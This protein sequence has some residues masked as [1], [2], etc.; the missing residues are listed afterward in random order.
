MNGLGDIGY[1]LILDDSGFR[2]T[3]RATQ[4]QLQAL[5]RQ[6]ASTGRAVDAIQSSISGVGGSFHNFVATMGAV[7]FAMLDVH[8]LFLALPQSIMDTSGQIE[9]LTKVLEGMSS[10]GTEA[11]RQLEAVSGVNFILGLEQRVPFSMQ[12][13]TDMFVKL[14][15]VGIDPAKGAAEALTNEV[16]KFGGGSLQLKEAS[17][18]IQQMLGKGSVSLQELRMQ[19]SQAIPN[20]AQKMA[21]AM[22]LS[23]NDLITKIKKGQ[24]E[25]SSAVGKMLAAFNLDSLGAGEAQMQTWIGLE[26]KLNTQWELWKKSVGDA[27]FFQAAKDSLNEL[28]D[29]FHT[30]EAKEWAQGLSDGLVSAIGYGKSLTA[31]IIE[32]KDQLKLAGE[33]ALAL[34][35]VMATKWAISGV[36]GG[37]GNIASSFRSFA[38]DSIA[39]ENLVM[40]KRVSLA[41]EIRA[42]DAK[43]IA[44]IRDVA[45][46]NEEALA[47]EIAANQRLMVENDKRYAAIDARRQADYQREIE[48]NQA[49]LQ[50]KTTLLA[51]LEAREIEATAFVAAEQDKRLA[52]SMPSNPATAAQYAQQASF[53]AEVEGRL[54]SMRAEIALIQEEEAALRGRISTLNAVMAAER[55]AAVAQGQLNAASS[56][57]NA[58]LVERNAVLAGQIAQSRQYAA[59]LQEMTTA[60]VLWKETTLGL[61]FA[62]DAVGGWMT[63]L[64]GIIVGGIAL[65][66]EYKDA[67]ERAAHAAVASANIARSI[68][69]GNVSQSQVDEF[70]KTIADKKKELADLQAKLIQGTVTVGGMSTPLPLDQQSAIRK[71]IDADKAALAEYVQQRAEA[72]KVLDAS[73]AES[74]TYKYAT[75]YGKD[76]ARIIGDIAKSGQDVVTAI[77]DK[78][79]AIGKASKNGLTELQ[80]QQEAT[81]VSAAIKAGTEKIAKAY[82]ARDA[83]LRK[84]IQNVSGPDAELRKAALQ[85]ELENVRN[86]EQN[87]VN[88]FV[89]AMDRQNVYLT[90]SKKAGGHAAPTDHL[91]N[92]LGNI[93]VQI[94]DAKAKLAQV[95]E[96]ATEYDQLRQQAQE[97]VQ[98]MIDAGQLDYVTHGKD[99]KKSMPDI[100]S[101]QAQD[102][103]D[104]MTTLEVLKNGVQQMR[105]LNAKIAP[106]QAEYQ[107]GMAMLATGDYTT[108]V[109]KNDN[110]MLAFLEKLSTRSL[111]AANDLAPLI[112]K[113]K[114]AQL[115]ADQVDLMNFTRGI[116]KTMQTDQIGLIDGRAEKLQAQFA[117][118]NQAWEQEAADRLNKVRKLGGDVAEEKA[119]ID[120]ADRVRAQD[121]AKKLETPMQQLVDKWKQATDTMQQASVNWSNSTIDAFV[122][123]A[124]TGKFQWQSLMES[125]VGDMLKASLQKKIGS[126]LQMG[127]DWLATGFGNLIGGNSTPAPVTA[128]GSS[129]GGVGMANSMALQTSVTSLTQ[130]FMG[131]AT[132]SDKWGFS[133]ADSVKGMVTGQSA[134]VVANNSLMTLANAAQIASS[135]LAQMSGGSV[136]SGLGGLFGA[137]GS[138]FGLGGSS[139]A[140]AGVASS[141]G[142]NSYGFTMPAAFAN[143]GIMTQ[144]GAMNLRKY[145]NGGIAN[146]PQLA[147]YGEG[148]SPE[149]FVPLPDGRSIPVTLSL[150]QQQQ[151]GSG[152][153][154]A[155]APPVTVNVINQT[156]Q[157]VQAQQGNTRFDG[158]QMIL[159]VVLSAASTPGP[160][161]D[162]MRGALK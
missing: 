161:R 32:Y 156:G 135:A 78:Y 72:K 53:T 23:M 118:E 150:A 107:Q 3:A 99:G 101:K 139:S 119:I 41:D 69:Q 36:A 144:F 89:A 117:I 148:S 128:Q 121:Q 61:K 31:T 80:K 24:V 123:A 40:Q 33:A 10:A 93:S 14:K 133:L 1:N 56:A 90:P 129:A 147:I 2:V 145:A 112:D 88:T 91:A 134:Q 136:G 28:V 26:E 84:Q 146:S 97:K 76:T 100:Q 54:A 52:M 21:D 82:Q 70:D 60:E 111:E 9:R 63:V 85:K 143:G 124:K 42:A 16:A 94:A 104:Q 50:A 130:K 15:T 109:G 103:I 149:A 65:W 79:D 120:A 46:A 25:A 92:R 68:R 22:G 116:G 5:E 34:G 159:D 8:G 59:A 131:L 27:G 125:I 11:K 75:Q 4:A 142:S 152:G 157:Q 20:A 102:L 154:A 106:L 39:T 122:N 86:E 114:Q 29:I 105:S 138:A 38:A 18:A 57:Q 113:M 64:A 96:G 81:E 13:L 127:F 66:N 44:T 55:E 35:A 158:K 115:V 126:S 71:Q 140:A 141:V 132:T 43:R 155:S 98:A 162:Q 74:D 83:D 58:A 47:A 19:L 137:M 151:T 153:Q 108:P 6:F 37:V 7:K 48:S 77:K 17:L 73:N 30:S 87:Q 110:S 160:F 95:V 45:A 12:S 62:F 67:S 51:E 49:I